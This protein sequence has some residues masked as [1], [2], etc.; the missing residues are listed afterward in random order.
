MDRTLE[1]LEPKKPSPRVH[2]QRLPIAIAL[3]QDKVL[4]QTH[5][6]METVVQSVPT[7]VT[8]VLPLKVQMAVW[9]KHLLGQST[10]QQPLATLKVTG[11]RRLQMLQAVHL[12]KDRIMTPAVQ[13]Q[14][15]QAAP[16]SPLRILLAVY[17]FLNP[18]K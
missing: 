11:H 14:T 5:H 4:T 3:P 7:K 1:T 13:A 16:L 9:V 17:P 12:V 15:Q 10:A 18:A 8:L 2:Q 6:A